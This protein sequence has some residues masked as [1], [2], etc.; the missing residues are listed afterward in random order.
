M[1]TVLRLIQFALEPLPLILE[2]R[3]N[4]VIPIASE[5]N[6]QI[7]E[8]ILRLQLNSLLMT[9]AISLGNVHDLDYATASRER[10]F[11]L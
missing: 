6:Q 2:K 4:F 8:V 10:I 11:S 7:W 5:V 9:F 1:F 3:W